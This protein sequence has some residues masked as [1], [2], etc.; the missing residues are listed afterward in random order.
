M[1]APT[2]PYDVRNVLANSEPS[3]RALLRLTAVLREG[4][5]VVRN[6]DIPRILSKSRL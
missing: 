3:T 6:P 1:A 5:L 4:P 2:T